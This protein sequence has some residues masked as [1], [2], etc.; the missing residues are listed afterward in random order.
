MI[1]M[2]IIMNGDGKYNIHY[3]Y[4]KEVQD[5]SNDNNMDIPIPEGGPEESSASNTRPSS[6]EKVYIKTR[7]F[8]ML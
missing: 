5:V 4:Y 1:I 2:I 3:D 8:S 7:S 6:E